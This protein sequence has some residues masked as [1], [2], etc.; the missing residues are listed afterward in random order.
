M[1][2]TLDVGESDWSEE[3]LY[4]Y[5][6]FVQSR[7]ADRRPDAD[8]RPVER[9]PGYVVALDDLTS[10]GDPLVDEPVPD[11]LHGALDDYAGTLDADGLDAL[12]DALPDDSD[13]AFRAETGPLAVAEF[14]R[15]YDLAVAVD[16]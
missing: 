9:T 11:S 2:L 14:A 10:N 7:R 5:Y 8:W 1:H 12:R 15:D 3:L 4:D 6:D 16:D 13:T